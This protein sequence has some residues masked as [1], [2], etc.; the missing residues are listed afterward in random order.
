[1]YTVG[2][3]HVHVQ[4]YVPVHA[5]FYLIHVAMPTVCSIVGGNPQLI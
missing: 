3:I 5:T 2:S 1:M 4:L